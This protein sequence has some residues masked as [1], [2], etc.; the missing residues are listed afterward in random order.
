M[1]GTIRA[2]V[3]LFGLV[4]PGLTSAAL[5]PNYERQREINA[6]VSSPQ[7]NQK[8]ANGV[9]QGI[10]AQGDSTYRVWSTNCSVIVTLVTVS[11]APGVAGPRQFTIQVGDPQCH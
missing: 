4:W 7:L 10:E 2:G 9:I 3:V 11:A 6:I 8:L 1:L 5:A